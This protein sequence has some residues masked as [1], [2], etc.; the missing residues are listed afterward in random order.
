ME[1]WDEWGHCLF[2]R[3]VLLLSLQHEEVRTR[4]GLSIGHRYR[5]RWMSS[6]LLCLAHEGSF[7]QQYPIKGGEYVLKA[8]GTNPRTKHVIFIQYLR[9]QSS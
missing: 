8:A 2:E 7:I 5:C 4:L 6:S 9:S 3:I 1:V